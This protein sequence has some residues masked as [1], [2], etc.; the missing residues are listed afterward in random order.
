VWQRVQNRTIEQSPQVLVTGGIKELVWGNAHSPFSVGQRQGLRKK[1]RGLGGK[2][3]TTTKKTV[4]LRPFAALAPANPMVGHR[5]SG[6]HF[7]IM[8][9]DKQKGF[10]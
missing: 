4:S 9:G 8:A 6:E 3:N 1:P 7:A 2:E 5:V 10:W